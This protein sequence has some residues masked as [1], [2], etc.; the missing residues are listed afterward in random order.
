MTFT[1]ITYLNSSPLGKNDRCFR[2]HCIFKCISM[3]EIFRVYQ[4]KLHWRIKIAIMKVIWTGNPNRQQGITWTNAD[5]VHWQIY[6]A[7]GEM[8]LI[9]SNTHYLLNKQ[10][11][12]YSV[13]F[14]LKSVN[15]LRAKFFRGN[16]NLYLHFMSFLHTNKTQVVEIPPQVRQGPSY[17]T[18]SISWLLMS[19][20]RKEPG[21]QQPWYWPS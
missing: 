9:Q 20:R 10:V 4:I 7:L 19:W 14:S 17:S 8:S 2:R 11:S 1:V 13:Q 18:Q 5:Q 21:H 3:N 16:I 12:V 15:P 6:V